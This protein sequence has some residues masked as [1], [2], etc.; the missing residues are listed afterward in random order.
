MRAGTYIYGDRSSVADGSVPLRDCA[1]HVRATVVSRPTAD[2]AIIDAGSKALTSDLAAGADGHGTL[3][4][5][6]AR[7]CRELNEEHGYVDLSACAER[8]EVG[9]GR[10]RPP[11]PRVRRDEPLR[12]GGRPPRRAGGRRLAGGRAR[13]QPVTVISRS[14][15]GAIAC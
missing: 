4:E 10:H 15:A 12:R 1:L 2:R 11:Q 14:S 9:G 6:P 8:P 5:Y 7:A 13:P 3:L